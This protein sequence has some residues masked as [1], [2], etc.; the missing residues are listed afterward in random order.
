MLPMLIV[1]KK[2][3]T[4]KQPG[5]RDNIHQRPSNI[6]Q[7]FKNTSSRNI[8]KNVFDIDLHHGPIRV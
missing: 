8:I 5:K 4:I 1:N 2:I 7:F 3:N 6:A